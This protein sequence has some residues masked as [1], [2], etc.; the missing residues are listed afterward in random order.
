MPRFC[1]SAVASAIV[2]TCHSC[3]TCH[4]FVFDTVNSNCTL[5]QGPWCIQHF[6]SAL[7]MG[8]ILVFVPFLICVILLHKRCQERLTCKKI[9]DLVA[10]V[11]NGNGSYFGGWETKLSSPSPRK[12]RKKKR[13]KGKTERKSLLSGQLGRE[14]I[15][16]SPQLSSEALRCF[17]RG[18]L[19]FS[20]GPSQT[21][22][23]QQPL[24]LGLVLGRRRCCLLS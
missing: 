6:H 21:P 9:K 19:Y 16:S 20:S 7:P 18:T 13:E 14:A 23:W 1:L 22:C 11:A 2:G 15:E 4:P 12:K 5:P 3:S 24:G 17:D 8:T 10:S